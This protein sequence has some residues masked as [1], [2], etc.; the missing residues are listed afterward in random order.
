MLR[1]AHLSLLCTA[2]GLLTL[3][4]LLN[5]RSIWSPRNR[6]IGAELILLLSIEF[7]MLLSHGWVLEPESNVQVAITS[8]LS[9]WIGQSIA[10]QLAIATVALS[11]HVAGFR[12]S[13]LSLMVI[14]SLASAMRGHLIAS[15]ESNVAKLASV[16]H[17][18]LATIWVAGLIGMLA[19]Q[20]T[21]LK[22]KRWSQQWRD[23]LQIFS[24]WALPGMLLL[25]ATGTFM[26]IQTVGSGAALLATRYGFM[27]TCKLA[28]LSLALLCAYQL[29]SWLK[30]P[31]SINSRIAVILLYLETGLALVVMVI[32]G[33]MAAQIPA[34]HDR[35]DWPFPF[36]IAPQAAIAQKGTDALPPATAAFLGLILTA[37]I[38]QRL[39][40]RSG[41]QATAGAI[42]GLAAATSIGLPALIVDA[43]PT[44]YLH[45][46]IP[47]DASSV[48]AGGKLYQQWCMNCHGSNG[49]GDG[50]LA[51]SSRVRPVNL[52]EPHVQWHTHGDLYWW[53]SSGIPQSG[54]PGFRDRL[55]DEERWQVM[56]LLIAVSMGYEARTI[57]DKIAPEDP[58]L[59]A[60]DFQYL[61][62]SGEYGSLSDW[63]R[64][65]RAVVLSFAEENM[66]LAKLPAVSKAMLAD[67]IVF[68]VIV[69]QDLFAQDIPPGWRA[70][71]DAKG[72][73]ALAWS[74]YRRT[75]KDP[76]FNNER[77]SV[78]GSIFLIDRFGFVR[79]R[80]TAAEKLP[81]IDAL[82]TQAMRL[83]RESKIRSADI[84]RPGWG[85]GFRCARR[86][87]CWRR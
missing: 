83:A 23:L 21:L 58:W 63:L 64:Q 81:S 7:F 37:I 27:L 6:L 71:V 74:N 62:A 40:R 28:V 42:I 60:I 30:G 61:S 14:T 44:T 84:R 43:Y 12:W 16:I 15:G 34:S 32:A 87:C 11:L 1:V 54:M 24:R 69:P 45:S 29:R 4:L 86:F 2:I 56:N 73:I 66:Q 47:Y 82:R 38:V 5:D 10:L 72:E 31:Y 75:L 76:D 55:S 13:A 33:W 52:T 48:A 25:L 22:D 20:S 78:N 8:A 9:T 79:A 80:W 19:Y 36:R 67:G 50:P 68:V 53:L 35:I 70:V 57:G 49:R 85:G 26:A 41:K 39:R 17:L 46:P 59:P 65:E 51:A 3:S 18:G 77:M